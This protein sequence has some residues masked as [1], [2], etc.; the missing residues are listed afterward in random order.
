MRYKTSLSLGLWAM[1]ITMTCSGEPSIT[2]QSDSA[3]YDHKLGTMV[4]SGNVVVRWGERVLHADE[5]IFVKPADSDVQKLIAK[6]NPAR[7]VDQSADPV[8]G[9]ARTIEYVPHTHWLTLKKEATLH[10][11]KDTFEGPS[12]SMNTQTKSIKATKHNNERPTFFLD[13]SNF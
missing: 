9:T 10:R 5:V 8:D 7:F 13:A 1:L 12:I 3:Q 11:Q 2:I 6:G 4:H